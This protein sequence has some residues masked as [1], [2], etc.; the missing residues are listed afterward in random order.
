MEPLH[1]DDPRQLGSYRLLRRLG[2]GGMGRVYLARSPGGRTVAVKAVRAEL[3][4]DAEFR[5]RFLQETEVARAVSGRFTAPVVD[6]AAGADV[7]VPWLAT[8]YVAGPAL[9]SV[10]A[11]H[12]PLPE[13]T[14]RALGCGLATAL[15]EVH[16]AGLVHRDLKPSNVL[17]AAD[18]PRVIDFGIARAVDGDR[19][20]RT[21]AVVGSPGY[22]SPEQAQGQEVGQPGDVF[23][24]GAVL[25]YAATGRHV[26]GR[27]APAALLYQVVHEEPDLTG[28]PEPLLAAIRACLAKDPAERPDPARV[29]ESLTPGGT[30]VSL[31]NAFTDWLPGTVS[32]TIATSAAALLDLDTPPGDQPPASAQQSG[33]FGPPPAP[34]GNGTGPAATGTMH[35]GRADGSAHLGRADGPATAGTGDAPATGQAG[36]AKRP[37]RRAFMG[38]ALAAAGAAAGT[39]VAVVSASGSGSDSDDGKRPARGDTFT[40]PPPGVAPQ[41]LWHK[42]LGDAGD[43]YD[44]ELLVQDD[45]FYVAGDPVRAFDVRTGKRTWQKGLT[46]PDGNAMVASGGVLYFGSGEY[47]GALVGIDS[48]THREVWRARLPGRLEAEA[49]LATD[50]KLLF[51]LADVESPGSGDDTNA[52]CAIDLKTRKKLWH[53]VRDKGTRSWDN[54]RVLAS[55]GH[56]VYAD[57]INVTVRETAHG[58]Q[59][60]TKRLGSTYSP[61]NPTIVPGGTLLVDG[62]TLRAYDLRT[63]KPKWEL[64][65][66]G[67]RGFRRPSLFDGRLYV[68][69]FDNG[70]W[71][72]DP[73]SGRKLWMREELPSTRGGDE[74]RRHGDTIYVASSLD[75]G[76]TAF[77]AK[78]GKHRWTFTDSTD[79]TGPWHIVRAGD[80]LIARHGTELY[81]LPAV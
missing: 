39:T 22:M 5:R 4:E 37:S 43:P 44:T 28:A 70:L 12:G 53:E 41:P 26:F 14:V 73:H 54:L 77:R 76:V 31:D 52:I 69:D 29:L 20:T 79:A 15:Q 36:T 34:Y 27:G 62:S 68:F 57:D 40:T 74:M 32:S 66:A 10:V 45:S 8:A 67:R 46:A 55:P 3:A 48:R 42:S 35:L 6:A 18:G 58:R 2:A 33:E 63:G 7:P 16:A 81:G 65:P 11:R 50:G 13:R 19:M 1:T 75:R 78:D 72:V 71:A 56:L 64:K 49:P 38:I 30:S 51:A 24:L 25:G 9:D 47:D 23:S 61:A 17:L 59:L 21:G 60:W 80:R